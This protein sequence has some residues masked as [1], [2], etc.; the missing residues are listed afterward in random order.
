MEIFDQVLS[1]TAA[2]HR[3][4]VIECPLFALLAGGRATRDQYVVYL[5][6]TF[7]L[8]RHTSRALARAASNVDDRRRDLR[9]WLL[10]QA[11][12]E[13][14]HE[15]FCLR[16]L[17]NLGLDADA[18]TAP[19][20]NPGAWGV[21]TQNYFFAAEGHPEALL[22][23]ASATEGMGAELAGGFAESLT[24]RYGIPEQAT[25]FLRSHAGFDRRHYAEV[26]EAINSMATPASLPWIVHGRCMTFRRFGELFHEVAASHERFFD[27]PR[28][29][30]AR[31]IVHG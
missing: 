28:A 12:E 21:I 7:H 4:Y 18:I 2:D 30:P 20:P 31:E 3:R 15:L 27:I 19:L 9:A 6:E 24:S 8:V 29:R 17:R 23:V 26:R 1:S 5:R 16:D 11:N 13:H 25:T 10:Q 22:G 14:G